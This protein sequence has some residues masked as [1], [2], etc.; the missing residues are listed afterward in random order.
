VKT[1]LEERADSRYAA[2]DYEGAATDYAALSALEPANTSYRARWVSSLY[3]ASDYSATVTVATEQIRLLGEAPA[4]VGLRDWYLAEALASRGAS[5]WFLDDK[6][7]ADADYVAAL[8]VVPDHP[9]ALTYRADLLLEQGDLDGADRFIRRA[10][11]A[12]VALCSVFAQRLR[13]DIAAARGEIDEARRYWDAAARMGSEEALE[14]LAGAYVPEAADGARSS[15]TVG[16]E[17][18]SRTS[19]AIRSS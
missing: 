17:S 11:E 16:H 7:G 3:D 18:R 1:S 5:R 6:V 15:A 13:G 2:G 19:D 9:R 8:E 10:W 12:G 14:R 4:G